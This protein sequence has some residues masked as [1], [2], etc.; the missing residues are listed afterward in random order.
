MDLS[1]NERS[2][3]RERQE[4]EDDERDNGDEPK[5]GAVEVGTRRPRGRPPGSKNKPKPPIFVTRDSPN[6]LK[7][8]VMEVAGG[9][10]VAESVAQFARR[11]QR[12]VCVLSGSGSVAN[13]TIRQP[14]A[15]GA[16]VALHGRFEILSLTGAF[17]PGPAPPGATGLT[18]YLAGG[19]S[20]IIGGSVV[21]S[22]VAAGPVMVIAATFANATYERLP[23]EE[24]EDDGGGS[25]QGGSALGGSPP[26]IGGNSGGGGSGGGHLQGGIPDPSSLPLYNLPPNLLSNGGQV[27]HEAFPWAGHGRQTY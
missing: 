24:E 17:L 26:G 10:D 27:G 14:A 25:V 9:A 20:Q 4:E 11:R 19:Q 16:V 22:L 12:G 2:V 23:L 15:P 5:E 3:S 7:S 1:I 8:H 21:G 13:V 6:S 18:V